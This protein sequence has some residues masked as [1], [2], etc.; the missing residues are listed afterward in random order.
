MKKAF[1]SFAIAAVAAVAMASC[2]N[3]SAANAEG[4][5]STAAEAQTEQ[6][7]EPQKEEV[8]AN[9]LEAEKFA[10]DLSKNGLADAWKINGKPQSKKIY[11]IPNGGQTYSNANFFFGA[12]SNKVVKNDV[13]K[14]GNK[15]LDNINVN[16]NDYE[17]YCEEGNAGTVYR[18]FQIMSDEKADNLML[19]ISTRPNKADAAA[20]VETLKN[21]LSAVIFK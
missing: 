15:K 9:L 13:I 16:G 7:E 12:G 8:N 6:A 14:R 21:L 4:Q 11:L 3:K 5:D 20:D 2:G 17:V 10:I 19:Q 18:A 1:F